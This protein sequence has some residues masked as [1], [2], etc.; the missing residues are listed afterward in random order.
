VEQFQSDR[1]HPRKT[2]PFSR[3]GA[4]IARLAERLNPAGLDESYLHVWLRYPLLRRKFDPT[5]RRSALA[6]KRAV[7]SWLAMDHELERLFAQWIGQSH[8]PLTRVS[9][10]LPVESTV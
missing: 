3:N 5:N 7:D 2:A 8:N 4:D 9:P 1:P 6:L 10:T